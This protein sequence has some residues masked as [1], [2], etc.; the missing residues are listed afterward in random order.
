MVASRAIERI[1]G[2]LTAAAL[3][4]D[5]GVHFANAGSYESVTTSVVS[6]ATLFRAQ[7][8]AA[9]VIAIVLL[10]RPRLVAWVIAVIVAAAALGAVL[11]YTNV[12]VGTLGPI[13]NMYEPTWALPGKEASAVAEGV[14]VLLALAGTAL[15]LWH[16]AAD[17]ATAAAAQLS[18]PRPAA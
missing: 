7:A 8:A 16:R 13:P 18:S 15:S 9:A 10:V 14:A 6:Q 11:L 1:L 12:N 5:A 3:G 2:V 17:R 4:V